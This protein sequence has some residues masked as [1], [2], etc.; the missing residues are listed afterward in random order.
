METPDDDL[1]FMDGAGSTQRVDL[2]NG[3]ILLPTYSGVRGTAK[4]SFSFQGL[5]FVMRCRF[6]GRTLSY[7]E[8]G[9]TLTLPT[10][11]ASRSRR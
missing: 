1:F 11:A 7:I 4:G 9:D 3:D 8:H 10:G 6:D 5:A 2:N